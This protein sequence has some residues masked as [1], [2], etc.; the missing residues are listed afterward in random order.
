MS[1]LTPGERR[2]L[3]QE[4][5][6]RSSEEKRRQH[7]SLHQ[8]ALNRIQIA[9]G[10][11][12][13]RDAAATNWMEI[14]RPIGRIEAL[15]TDSDKLIEGNRLGKENRYYEH[16]AKWKVVSRDTVF[17]LPHVYTYK[18]VS[19]HPKDEGAESTYY[20]SYA[21]NDGIYVLTNLSSQGYGEPVNGRVSALDGDV[22]IVPTY[23]LRLH[24]SLSLGASLAIASALESF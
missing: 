19:K 8:D 16:P 6:H 12:A 4:A 24:S 9:L 1:Y 15:L 17:L 2:R 20:E 18:Q 14:V 3:N 7:E 13:S 10:Y 23:A 22:L 21:I 5:T 11:L